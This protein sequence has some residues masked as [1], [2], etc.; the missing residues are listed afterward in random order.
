MSGIQRKSDRVVA[1]ALVFEEQI[2]R[3]ICAYAPQMEK[4]ECKNNQFYN[5]KA[6]EWDL[7]NPHE[8][9][10]GIGD[11]NKHVRRQID[12]FEGMHGEYEIHKRN[13]EGRRPLELCDEKELCMANT[14]FEKKQQKEIAI[15]YGQKQN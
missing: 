7:Q 5:D 4:L 14:W 15:Q 6:G 8:V 1:M 13:V 2:L 9:V 12:G 11:F 10:L 3:V